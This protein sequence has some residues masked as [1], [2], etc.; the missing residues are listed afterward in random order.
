[1]AN[2]LE[3]YATEEQRSTVRFLWAKWLIANYI[4]KEMILVYVGKCLSRKAVHNWV[5]NV[6]LIMKRLKLRWGSGLNN[7]LYAEVYQCWWRICWEINVFVS[8]VRMSL[9]YVLY[10][11]VTYLLTLPC[12]FPNLFKLNWGQRLNCDCRM[13]LYQTVIELKNLSIGREDIQVIIKSVFPLCSPTA[14]PSGVHEV[15][16]TG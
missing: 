13:T 6:S 14:P 12:T 5:A 1:M 9:F 11:S 4:H 15:T 7:S 8:Q 2:V 3:E 10:P 16:F